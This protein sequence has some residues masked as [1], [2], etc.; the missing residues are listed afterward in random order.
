[1]KDFEFVFLIKTVVLVAS[2]CKTGYVSIEIVFV[3]MEAS[4]LCSNCR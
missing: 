1:M 4:C 3:T 2:V